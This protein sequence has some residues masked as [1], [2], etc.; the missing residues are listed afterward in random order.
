MSHTT[1][2]G[3]V[4]VLALLLGLATVPACAPRHEIARRE[5]GLPPFTHG[6]GSAERLVVTT[7]DGVGLATWVMKPDSGALWP[8]LLIRSPYPE[9]R[10]QLALECEIYT[11]YGYACVFQDARGRGESEGEW[12]PFEHERK[13]GIDTVRWL[14]GQHWTDGNVGLIGA[15]YLAFAQWAVADSLPPDVRTIVP[16]M[17]G[18]NRHAALYERGMFRADVA[19]SWTLRHVGPGLAL[20]RSRRFWHAVRHRPALETDERFLGGRLP[21]YRAWLESPKPDDELWSKGLWATV[22]RTPK[23][24]RVPVLLISGWYDHGLTGTFEAYARL[25][26]RERSLLVVGPWLHGF[27]PAGDG[28]PSGVTYAARLQH[29]WLEHWLKGEPSGTPIRGVHAYVMGDDFQSHP[30]WPPSSESRRWH[31]AA[32]DDGSCPGSLRREAPPTSSRIQFRYDP[33]DPVPTRGGEALLGWA[34]GVDAPRPGRVEQAPP[35]TRPDVLSFVSE[36]LA[37][38]VVVMGSPSVHLDV[39]SSAEDS[40]FTVKLVEVGAAGRARNVRDGI[41]SLAYASRAGPTPYT[42]GEQVALDLT[43]SPVAIRLAA[44]SRLRLDVSSSNFP[45]YHAH[46]NHAGPWAEQREALVAT[47]TLELGH[48]WLEL[49]VLP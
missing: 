14:V 21:W 45:A 31:L 19:T 38:D 49:P 1:P 42:P 11:R 41:S 35:C 23:F 44:G 7:R 8:A 10:S 34:S 39:A 16:S 13:D 29:R 48:A 12:V 9:L 25:K 24:T 33:D 43:L 15:S 2:P 20:L 36:P 28:L 3:A 6:V 17:F 46:P 26:S 37:R 27:Q 47:Q 22:R 30:D 18:P 4:R 5:N 32:A 40:A